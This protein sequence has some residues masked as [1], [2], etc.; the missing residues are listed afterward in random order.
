[1]NKLGQVKVVNAAREKRIVQY[2]EIYQ[3]YHYRKGQEFYVEEMVMLTPNNPISYTPMDV[4]ITKGALKLYEHDPTNWGNTSFVV[5][6]VYHGY[7]RT[8]NEY[9]T[10][11]SALNKCTDFREKFPE[12]PEFTQSNLEKVI[13]YYNENCE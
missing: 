4:I 6:D 8:K 3:V 13:H 10:L 7:I 1:M 2:D 9:Y 11:L 12:K 5:S